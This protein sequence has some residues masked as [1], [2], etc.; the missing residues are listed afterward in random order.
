LD[1]SS[2]L[3]PNFYCLHRGQLGQGNIKVHSH[4]EQRFRCTTCGKTFTASKSTPSCR[5]HKP[6]A[7][8]TVVLTL[9]A[10]GCPLQA[11]VA[12]YGLDERTVAD[13]QDIAGRHSHRFHQLNVPQR[14]VDAQHIQADELWVKMVGR[15]VWM[16]LAL[17]VPSRLWLGGVIS[18]QRDGRLITTLVTLVKS[19]LKT[20]AV[21]VCVDGLA[22][23]V[24][25]FQRVF[26]HKVQGRR[27]RPQ[28]VVEPGLL[29]G[30]V[31]KRRRRVDQP[32]RPVAA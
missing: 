5:L 14:Q 17:T 3:C 12:A 19:C 2:A 25:A 31:I 10:H 32:Q 30:Q 20:L 18:R 8:M 15:K 11:I 22:S 27:G 9:L 28:L 29:I 7:L 4:K 21:L 16:A 1:P 24:T 6:V 23:Y 26:R 13:W